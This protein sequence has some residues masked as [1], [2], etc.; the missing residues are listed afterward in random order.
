MVATVTDIKCLGTSGPS[1]DKGLCFRHRLWGVIGVQDYVNIKK[2]VNTR[3]HLY[4]R[5]CI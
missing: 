4:K 3:A 1:T 5:A 2:S